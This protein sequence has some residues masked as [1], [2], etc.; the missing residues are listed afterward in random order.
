MKKIVRLTESDLARIVRRVI[1]E[2]ATAVAQGKVF[3]GG[4][5]ISAVYAPGEVV[6]GKGTIRNFSPDTIAKV[7]SAKIQVTPEGAKL[8]L[9]PDML[10]IKMPATVGPVTPKNKQQTTGNYNG[11][12][13][14]YTSGSYDWTLK[15]PT[16]QFTNTT[17]KPITLFM[18]TFNTNDFK[19]PEMPSRVFNMQPNSQFGVQGAQSQN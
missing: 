2:G 7:F 10:T 3:V 1:S 6:T 17:G 5:N 4:A 11:V 8:G 16:K 18:I 19:T 9:T 12:F 15:T 13:M 14:D